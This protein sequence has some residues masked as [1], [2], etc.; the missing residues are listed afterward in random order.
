M[1]TPKILINVA[2]MLLVLA[3]WLSVPPKPGFVGFVVMIAIDLCIAAL[4]LYTEG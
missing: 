1:K 4:A 3:A 2:A